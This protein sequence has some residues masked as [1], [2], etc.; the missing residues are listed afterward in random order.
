MAF[1]KST[2]PGEA[3][4]AGEASQR[5]VVDYDWALAFGNALLASTFR[6]VDAQRRYYGWDATTEWT[7]A[8]TAYRDYVEALSRAKPATP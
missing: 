5:L 4:A 3:G 2:L 8:A 6:V 7:Q 1:N